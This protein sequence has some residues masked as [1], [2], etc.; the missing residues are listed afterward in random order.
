[1]EKTAYYFKVATKA[2]LF[3]ALTYKS[4]QP[5]SP[6]QRVK[7]PLGKR[8]AYGMILE[9]DLEGAKLPAVREILEIDQ[10]A[11][12]ISPSRI[13]WLKWISSYYHY[14]L[15]MVADLS[16]L[17]RQM[18]QKLNKERKELKSGSLP[19]SSRPESSPPESSFIDSERLLVL[20]PEQ[21][22][23][24]ERILKSEGFN[25][26]LIHGVTG[27][28]KTEIYKKLIAQVLNRKGQV[29]VLLPE[30]FL[31]PQI[32]RRFSDS[33]PGQTAL[34]HSQITARQKKQVWQ[35]L[36][37]GKKNLLVGTRSA[38]FCPL[39]RLQLVIIDEEHDSSFKQEEKF[40]YH[41]R[42]SAIVLAKE[43]GIPIALGSATPDFSSYKKALDGAYHLYELKQRAFKQALPQVTVVDLKSKPSEGRPFW[44]S[45][46]LFDKMR[47]TLKSGRQTALFVNRRGQATALICPQCG[48]IQKCLNCDISL[49]LHLD[50]CLI[51]HY[52]SHIEKKPSHCPACRGSEWLERGLGT[53]KAQQI[54]ESYFPEYKIVRADRDSINSREEMESFIEIV[55]QKQAQIIIG[56]QMLSKGLN[57]PSIY[58]VGLV[59]ADMDFHFPDFRAGERAFQTL[60]QM[61]GRAGRTDFGEVILQ[62][63]N[64]DHLSISFAKQH[65]YKGFFY[66]E[67]KSR[68]KWSYPPFF[69]LCLLKIPTLTLNWRGKNKN[70]GNI[71]FFVIFFGFELK[72]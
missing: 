14:P 18:S 7:I 57:F 23:C 12:S 46:I 30:I 15:G 37:S 31:T 38:L 11:P 28:G 67:I 66:E 6:G 40:R 61:S 4:A 5:L 52:C 20:T 68:K 8:K 45:D 25:I 1:M 27:S 39:P 71:G 26:H 69:R 54:L 64:P 49:T 47:K 50:N 53:Q 24:A 19:E 36:L 48:H 43:L 32:V 35:S 65:D 9:E 51:C 42:D 2:P 56:T 58:L 34:L 21:E 72:M 29:L 59:L 62:T 33:F 70:P 13:R 63:F 55:E 22:L 44:L 10:T 17:N 3:K 16:F 41:A 60:I